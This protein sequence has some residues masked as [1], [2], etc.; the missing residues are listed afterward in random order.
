MPRRCCSV[1][2]HR[3]SAALAW[4][5]RSWPPEAHES[6]SE[7]S[8]LPSAL[9]RRP[10]A[11]E[12]AECPE[13]CPWPWS[14]RAPELDGFAAWGHPP[15]RAG[16][17]GFAAWGHPGPLALLEPGPTEGRWATYHLPQD[18]RAAKRADTSDYRPDQRLGASVEEVVSDPGGPRIRGRGPPRQPANSAAPDS[19]SGMG[20]GRGRG[21]GGGGG[22]RGPGRGLG[23]ASASAQGNMQGKHE[24]R[25]SARAVVAVATQLGS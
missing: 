17:D 22:G 7:G 13:E 20:R 2:L 12:P 24:A 16:A 14:Q 3:Q 11:S 5:R 25:P 8:G 9:G 6:A 15:A 23:L 19:R 1:R 10:G 21:A 4:R 18:S